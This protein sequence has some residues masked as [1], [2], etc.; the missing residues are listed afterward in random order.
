VLFAALLFTGAPA[1]ALDQHSLA[2]VFGKSFEAG[3]GGSLSDPTAVAVDEATGDVYVLDKGNDRVVRFGP[4]HEFIEA[5][6]FGVKA[7]GKEYEQCKAG[8]GC[9]VGIAGFG[10]GQLDEPEGIAVDNDS[11]SPSHG[12]VYV[13][14]NST[15]AKA[16]VD[17]FTATGALVGLLPLQS[18]EAE[19]PVDGVAVDPTGTVWVEREDGEESFQ[20][21]RFSDGEKAKKI[22]EASGGIT[23][24]NV[25]EEEGEAA[26]TFEENRPVRPGFAID[27]HDDLYIT[28]S[29]GALDFEE[30]QAEAQS[31]N[32]GQVP[33]EQLGHPCEAHACYTAKV[34]VVV[35]GE[36]AEQTVE[37][38]SVPEG[39]E[40]VTLATAEVDGEASGGVAVDPAGAG[41]LA[42]DAFVEN[43]HSVGVFTAADAPVERFS[44]EQLQGAGGG[45]GLAV[46]GLT[47]EALLA[48]AQSGQ[49]EQ[50]DFTARKPGAPVVE[51]G[52][53][54]PAHVSAT[55]AEARALVEP[56]GASTRYRVQYG[57]VECQGHEASCKEAA[58]T[59]AEEK[60]GFGVQ[61][62]RVKLTGLAPS[63]TY[64]FRF[65][66]ENE[67]AQGVD[68]V[69]SEE[70]T[71]TTQPSPVEATLLDGR[72]WELVTPPNKHGAAIYAIRKE[73]GQIQAAAD[74]SSIAYLASSP[75]GESEPTG[76][77]GPEAAEIVATHQPGASGAADP[78]SSEDLATGNEA[79]SQGFTPGGPWEYQA[80]STSLA[81]G[82]AAPVSENPLNVGEEEA[83]RG[84]DLYIREKECTPTEKTGPHTYS[85]CFIPLVNAADDSS[86]VALSLAEAKLEFE[87]A[88]SNFDDVVF[89]SSLPLTK[90][91]KAV[92]GLYLWSRDEAPGERLQLI[93][94][95]PGTDE[96]DTA[97]AAFVGARGASVGG[98]GGH[99]MAVTS[100]S[101][102]PGP[103]GPS[104]KIYW[105][106]GAT[107]LF[108]TE[109]TKQ[110]NTTTH[111]IEPVASAVSVAE[112]NTGVASEVS[113]DPL[114]ETATP[115]GSAAFF[116]D[117][118]K[119]TEDA[120]ATAT[121]SLTGE[122]YA[123]E[124]ARAGGRRV[125]D[126]S[127]DLIKGES[128]DVIGGPLGTGE[129]DT[130]EA[131]VYFVADGVLS[132]AQ[133]PAG[134]HA[135]QGAC[136]VFAPATHT[137]NLYAAHRT[138]EGRW[139]APR[140]VVQLSAADAPDWGEPSTEI[141]AYLQSL[142]TAR[143]SPNGEYVSF[144]SDRRLLGYDNTDA[145]SGVPDE[146]VYVYRYADNS[147]VCASC[148]PSGAQPVGVEDEQAGGEGEGLLVDRPEAWAQERV[149]HWL[150]G[151]IPTWTTY[152]LIP[153][154]YQSRYLSNEG[155]LFFDSADALV[156][157]AKPT[158]A[159][160]VTIGG[161]RTE[162]QVG[163]ENVYEY[164]PTGTGTCEAA[165]ANTAAGKG[166]VQL[167]SSGESEQ[168][169]AFIDA[170]ETGED[171]FFVTDA[172]LSPRDTDGA[173]DIYDARQCKLGR[174]GEEPCAPPPPEA[175]PECT[176]EEC[177][178]APEEQPPVQQGSTG[179]S[180]GSA[181]LSSA[182]AN[183]RPTVQVLGTISHK[184]A[185]PTRAQLLA[186]A[187][188][189][190]KKDKK[191]GKRA[192]CERAAHKKY[193]TRK[194]A[195]G[196][197][198]DRGAHQAHGASA[199]RA[200][201]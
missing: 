98:A 148:N 27:A 65:V 149:D 48:N 41:A 142:Q 92:E 79:P 25:D 117:R 13:V 10:H 122:L 160:T 15:K 167:I 51:R 77:R 197:K 28:Y 166:C 29:P 107:K 50:Y 74:G 170:S 21:L 49:V 194:P 20:V 193:A 81:Q 178:P 80:F 32:K 169:S 89:T 164:E 129:S 125:T 139:E 76:Y 69:V 109:V 135:T 18:S 165:I 196:K 40:L 136:F 68:A 176:G 88:T 200:E 93:S 180:S 39:S 33:V 185:K 9:R 53:V 110:E 150:A 146:E 56:D 30:L 152:G 91:G 78:W 96:Q 95:L 99:R 128:A 104:I 84:R 57:E 115:N 130:G 101:E 1:E 38:A 151:S 186:K 147:L 114:F 159:E 112:P 43:I 188:A 35:V 162:A 63:T 131:T 190:C 97:G 11:A 195:K 42:Q 52:S 102:Q 7:G 174:A 187:L 45:A 8:E 158:R 163:V 173:F 140:F 4:A 156:P 5:W 66:V 100:I 134:E 86:S 106:S 83:P 116:E 103:H 182:D 22:G 198:A 47:S 71:F 113:A 85:P 118:E 192:A 108:L 119:L 46:D 23:V 6:G 121:S 16:A 60:E 153:S 59:P 161:A 126:L 67:F 123:F 199:A 120:H 70:H 55:A 172:K 94:L 3:A 141:A 137:C 132:D 111:A 26:T 36:G 37:E 87:A 181:N 72:A 34:P 61:E 184:Q 133:G 54:F 145:N 64:H 14:A 179:A 191:K 127:P 168:E 58:P 75:V 171:V 144:M 62:L 90:N 19:G 44:S 155:R 138:R 154:S 177:R 201:G 189:S 183:L 105:N 82:L 157:V 124:P 31:L 24:P 2:G 17:K 143:V 175:K 12:D 73:G